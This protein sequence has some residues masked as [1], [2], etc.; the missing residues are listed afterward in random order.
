MP[1]TNRARPRAHEGT[2]IISLRAGALTAAI[3]ARGPLTADTV[4]TC[5]E[6]YFVMVG[7]LLDS[8][9]LTESEARAL[10]G[11][12]QDEPPAALAVRQGWTLAQAIAVTD[13]IGRFWQLRT[14]DIPAGLRAVGLVR[15]G[16]DGGTMTGR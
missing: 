3:A 2:P 8:V 5:L 11:R 15:D 1:F 12:P 13:A 16:D 6:R 4:K 7:G 9:T 14:T 10:L